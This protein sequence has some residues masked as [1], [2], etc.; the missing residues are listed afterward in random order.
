[1][2][3]PF[4]AVVSPNQPGTTTPVFSA[5]DARV[6]TAAWYNNNLWF[7]LMDSLQGFDD[8]RIAEIDTSASTMTQNFDWT[9]FNSNNH[10]DH[11]F[12]PALTVDAMGNMVM[13]YGYSNQDDYPS[14]AVSEQ[15]TTDG[16]NWMEQPLKV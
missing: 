5:N 9:Q 11:L 14:I 13:V 2:M 1:P 15:A 10:Q 8:I 4:D 3:L 6:E 12:F 16:L 7:A